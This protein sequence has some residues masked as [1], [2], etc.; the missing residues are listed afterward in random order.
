MKNY[1]K[2]L[3]VLLLSTLIA[4]S[5][6][7][8]KAEAGVLTAFGDVLYMAEDIGIGL[9]SLSI[10]G[11]MIVGGLAMINNFP[12]VGG[13]VAGITI[14]VLDAQASVNPNDLTNIFAIKY[15]FVDNRNSLQILAKT[16]SDKVPADVKWGGHY[17]INLTEDEI[18]NAL[19]SSDLTE[20]Q[21]QFIIRSLR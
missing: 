13:Q 20:E 6:P 8:K 16:V 7:T 1:R 4:G 19:L 17:M 3:S 5:V 14:L 2:P 10:S 18:K 11:A 12:G 9:I 15:P 21:L